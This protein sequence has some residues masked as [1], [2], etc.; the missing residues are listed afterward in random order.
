MSNQYILDTERLQFRLITLTD[1]DNLMQIFSD[2][3]AMQYYPN[4]KDKDEAIKWIECIIDTQDKFN[5]SMMA[6]ELKNSNT[7]V[8]QC[9]FLMQDVNG[10]KEVEIGYLFVR[11]YWNNGYATEATIACKLYAFSNK[12]DSVIS[13]IRPENKA[14]LR[15]AEKNGM[16][17]NEAIYKSG[18]LHRVYRINK[19]N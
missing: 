1:I 14:S 5:F 13:L 10:K 6:C 16:N 15:V 2:P 9:G 17:Y 19:N 18:L 8:G 3:I 11:K 7:F 12:I 4:V